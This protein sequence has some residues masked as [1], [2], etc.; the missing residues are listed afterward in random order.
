MK[1]SVQNHEKA[2]VI[3]IA[4]K[5]TAVQ[6][7]DSLRGKVKELLAQGI[8]CIVVDLKNLEHI[9]STGVGELVAA[10]SSAQH[11]DAEFYLVRLSEQVS[12]ILEMTNLNDVFEILD[13][14]D[15]DVSCIL[16]AE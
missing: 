14:T 5:L 11:D 8:T 3:S 1:L 2:T 6:Y 16:S 7:N 4:G 9:D 12:E 10:Y 13:E 15:P